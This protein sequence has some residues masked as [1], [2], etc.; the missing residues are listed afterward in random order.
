MT[1]GPPGIAS[2]RRH[3]EATYGLALEGLGDDQIAGAI[4]AA[5]DGCSDP[6][7]AAFLARVVDRLP[8]DES[9]LFREDGLW[10]WLRDAAGPALLEAAA[11]AARPLRVLSVGCSS[12][13]EPFSAAIVLQGL[14]ERGG[15]PPSAAAEHARIVGLDP[16]PAR[17]EAA[18][19]GV[20]P[21][22]SVQ[23]ARPGWLRGRVEPED[24]AGT[25]F[26]VAPAV[27]AMCRFDVGNLVDLAAR[28]NAALAGYDL[29]LCR[30][31]LIYFRPAEAERLAGALARALDPGAV[32]VL[33]APEAHL[34]AAGGL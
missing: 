7:D 30:H 2:A 20:L 16:S 12:G 22:W 3:L 6:A 25:R 4:R 8:I 11:A 17:V 10:E 19:L 14:L 32:L 31:V 34:L 33:S 15:I 29:V 28:G 5:A 24:D 18:R 13:Q 27:R 26:R 1:L 21:A 23:R 9:W